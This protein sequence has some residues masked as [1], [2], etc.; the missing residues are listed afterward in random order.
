[1]YIRKYSIYRKLKLY[2]FNICINVLLV[3]ISEV[4]VHIDTL[5]SIR[6]SYELLN[7]SIKHR[8]YLILRLYPV[9]PV[10][11]HV[12]TCTSLKRNSRWTLLY[13]SLGCWSSIF[14][15]VL[16]IYTIQ[17]IFSTFVTFTLDF[18]SCLRCGLTGF[19][20]FQQLKQYG[21]IY[22]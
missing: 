17:L 13:S 16:R 2:F 3:V 11:F 18:I 20:S 8:L 21:S 10:H 4:V 7:V 9:R 5:P 6:F 12:L 1:M 22:F 14:L 15:L 19:R